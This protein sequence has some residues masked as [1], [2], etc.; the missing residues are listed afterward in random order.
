MR[1]E[2]CQIHSEASITLITKPDKDINN[3]KLQA[4]IFDEYI[5]KNFN[6]ILA[7]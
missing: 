6:K 4:Y 3:R 1:A 2:Y 7:N 5:C